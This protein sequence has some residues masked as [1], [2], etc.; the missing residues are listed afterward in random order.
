MRS[1]S[2]VVRNFQALHHPFPSRRRHSPL[3][4]SDSDLGHFRWK[5]STDLRRQSGK[6]Q[7]KPIH[8]TS[9]L[10]IPAVPPKVTKTLRFFLPFR[11]FTISSTPTWCPPHVPKTEGNPEKKSRKQSQEGMLRELKTAKNHLPPNHPFW[12]A[13]CLRVLMMVQMHHSEI[14]C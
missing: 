12:L 9:L 13:A 14:L 6:A 1:I 7:K 10:L 2:G 11:S 8:L 5:T 4:G 3:F